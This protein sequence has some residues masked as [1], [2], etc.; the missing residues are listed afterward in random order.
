MTEIKGGPSPFRIIRPNWLK[1]QAGCH[2]GRGKG[3]D[4]ISFAS[5]LV[6]VALKLIPG[7]KRSVQR[8][9]VDVANLNHPSDPD[10]LDWLMLQRGVKG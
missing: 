4:A 10:Y 7:E 9:A 2:F 6:A 1:R 5:F 8:K 3:Y